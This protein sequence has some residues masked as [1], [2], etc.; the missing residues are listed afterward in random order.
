VD[1]YW[2][3]LRNRDFFRYGTRKMLSMVIQQKR[4][5]A[6]DAQRS[7]PRPFKGGLGF[8][9]SFLGGG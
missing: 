8:G 3:I 9:Q 4:L 6:S 5:F 1:S 7:A 2:A